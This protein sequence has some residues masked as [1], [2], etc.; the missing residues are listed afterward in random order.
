MPA[1][2]KRYPWLTELLL[3]LSGA[4]L[5]AL[6]F[7]S[8]AY[9][10]GFGFLGYF[11]LIPTF[12]LI[13]RIG[14]AK[15]AIYG[16]L[17][18]YLA[19][20]LLNYWLATFNPVS[21]VVVPMIYAVY[22]LFWFPVFKWADRMFP[23]WGYLV[24]VL[25]WLAYEIFRVQGFLG[26]SYGILGYTQY[27]NINLIGIADI[28]GILGVSLLVVFPSAWIA[29][30]WSLRKEEG[31][32]WDVLKKARFLTIPGILYL[33]FLAGSLGYSIS[34]KVDYSDTPVWRTSL[35]Q[36]D[37]NAWR[38]GIEV[39][40]EALDKLIDVSDEALENNPDA[41]IWSETAFVPSIKWHDRH[42][43]ERDKFELVQ[44]LKEYFKGQDVP[45]LIGNN[46]IVE[47]AGNRES[48]NAVLVFQKDQIVDTYHKI[49]LVPF[50]EHFP[51]EKIFPRFYK[52][53]LNNGV[54]F[55]IHGDEYTVFDMGQAKAS[56]LI[57]FEDTFGDLSRNFVREGA[58]VLVNVS[59][60]SWSPAQ[61]CSIQ[62]AGM[63]V[64]RSVENRRSMV[65]ATNGGFTC[66]IDPN[67]RIIQWL[68]PFTADHL[69]VDVPVYDEVD[70]F[71]TRT[72][73]LFDR[74]V[75]IFSILVIL[76]MLMRTILF[77]R[78]RRRS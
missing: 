15:S 4:L 36:H 77:L 40:R 12:L 71:Y 66:M 35:I 14:I 2:F 22:F 33:V 48:Y 52:Y 10:W 54:T 39:Y 37:I 13:R 47:I 56:P 41:V 9:R 20:T 30:L 63:A 64:F 26:Y 25:F 28:A 53:I 24:Q 29:R 19:Y 21:F 74:F 72:P 31:A 34:S 3:L 76:S 11:C 50:G 42:R 43:Q 51:Y 67:G 8:F 70:T 60:D 18:G 57:C 16:F 6:A 69:T 73:F 32:G 23:R 45:F 55:Y 7:P 62:H 59:N 1:F 78:K 75:M 49:H 17:Y 38:S 58:Q 44:R 5:F 61:A 68:E 27:R 65:R 46:D